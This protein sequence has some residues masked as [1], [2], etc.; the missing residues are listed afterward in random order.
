MKKRLL[1]VFALATALTLQAGFTPAGTAT[2]NLALTKTNPATAQESVQLADQEQIY[3]VQLMT[4]QERAE[5]RAKMSAAKTT[6]EREQIRKE[7]HRIM[8]ERSESHGMTLPNQPPAGQ[9]GMGQGG[10][11]NRGGGMGNGGG[12][13]SG[14]GRSL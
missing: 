6:E 2:E 4:P 11:M 3:G 10:G 12:M 1:I 14:R 7:N 8:Q 13:G 9:G 5:F